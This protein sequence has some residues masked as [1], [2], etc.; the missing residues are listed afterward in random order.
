MAVTHSPDRFADI[1]K[2]EVELFE[3]AGLGAAPVVDV[4]CRNFYGMVQL[5]S[6]V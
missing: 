5:P 2:N 4:C 6:D 1:K 3:G